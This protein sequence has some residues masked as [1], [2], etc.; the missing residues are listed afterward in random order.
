MVF[1]EPDSGRFQPLLEIQ[2]KGKEKVIEEQ[3]ARDLLTLQT[4]KKKSPA[5]QF[6]FQRRT[7]MTTEP[8]GTAGSPSLDVE[9]ALA[10]SETES[11]E[12]DISVTKDTEMEVTLTETPATTTGVHDKGQ[13]GSDLGKA[14][15]VMKTTE[16]E[17]T[18]EEQI[19]EEFASTMYP[20]VQDNL[21]LPVEEHV[22]LEEPTSSTGTLSSLHHLDKD[23]NFSDQFINDKSSDAEKEK[24]HAESE[25][26]SMVTVTIH[27]TLPLSHQYIQAV[28]L[29]QPKTRISPLFVFTHY[30]PTLYCHPQTTVPPTL[31]TATST[32]TTISTATTTSIVTTSTPL[33]PPSQAPQCT[34]NSSI[35]SRLYDA[36]TH[37]AKLVQA[38]LNLEERLK[39]VKS[40]YL[41]GMIKKQVRG[42]LQMASNL[43]ERINKHASRLYALENLNISHKVKAAV[44]EIV[45]DVVD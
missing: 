24:T 11:D 30:R 39:K 25:V 34:T 18:T 15:V 26:E 32:T 16:A 4:P 40:Q 22:I 6:I 20:N 29:V 33:L 36:L 35:K 45:T 37:I 10:D 38:N 41:S 7:P 8:S 17:Q 43:D 21:K 9:L 5:D 42:Y 3:V 44:D 12:P 13:G 2:G 14:E 23:F 27:Q 31:T 19:H 1:R 28:D